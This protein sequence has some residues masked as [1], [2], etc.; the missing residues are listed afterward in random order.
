MISL[1]KN[2]LVIFFFEYKNFY[3]YSKN[4]YNIILNMGIIPCCTNMGTV[5]ESFHEANQQ[6]I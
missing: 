6:V 3:L 1:F 4:K 2:F 5:E